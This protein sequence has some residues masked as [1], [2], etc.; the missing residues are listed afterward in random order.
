MA[1]VGSRELLV[2][3][4]LEDGEFKYARYIQ[5]EVK[6]SKLVLFKGLAKYLE[7]PNYEIERVAQDDRVKEKLQESTYTKWL[8]RIV[9]EYE[10]D[11]Q[12]HW[13]A[14]DTYMDFC[15][16]YGD[17]PNST[18]VAA[19]GVIMAN[20]PAVLPSRGQ[21]ITFNGR[22]LEE[23]G[24]IKYDLLSID[25]LC[26]I[27]DFYGLDI[28]WSGPKDDEAV[29]KVFQDGDTDFTFQF[30]SN[31]M[32]RILKE[33]KPT[34]IA[35]L[36]AINALFRPGPIEMGMVDK[37]IELASG[38]LNLE[39]DDLVLSNLLKEQ[40]GEDHA[41]LVIYQ[42]DV[43]KICQ[44]GAGFTLTEAD[45]I[46]KAMGKKDEQKMLKYKPQF[47]NG[48]CLEGDPLVI[49][50]NLEKF[51]HYAF[52]KSHA[53]AYAV[54]A[55][56]TARIWAHEKNRFL[57][58]HLNF[59]DA[60]KAIDKCSQLGYKDI[61]P[62]ITNMANE[63]Y[64]IIDKTVLLPGHATENVDTFVK[65]LF[66]RD[67]LSRNK[68]IYK[69]VCDKLTFDRYGLANLI[70]NL[71]AKHK[72]LAMYMEGNGE[73]FTSLEQILDGLKLIGAVEEWEKNKSEYKIRVVKL[74]SKADLIIR[75]N[76]NSDVVSDRLLYDMKHFGK[77]RTGI[78]S[79]RL[80]KCPRD[81]PTE[82]MIEKLKETQIAR[83]GDN[84]TPIKLY[85]ILKEK[86][87]EILRTE[88]SKDINVYRVVITKFESG[89]YSER[90]ICK[91]SN[92]EEFL[93]APSKAGIGTKIRAMK[94]RKPFVEITVKYSPFI[95]KKTNEYI[96][97][98]DVIDIKEI[99]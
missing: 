42:E 73:P 95:R 19:S 51:S 84:A 48:W 68:L 39:G 76:M 5:N 7:I 65:F 79:D 66:D 30:G 20:E 23:K 27:Q 58:Y 60:K 45:H 33:T 56:E 94:S 14:V 52:N 36:A 41:G 24:F 70:D 97:D 4:L 49:W 57:E 10:L 92:S 43:M 47:I 37:Y 64:K 67:F 71:Q 63:Q 96:S 9:V 21:T 93:T 90:V 13:D 38:T 6:A 16:K 77:P 88:T 40:F 53:V 31:G 46:R 2:D 35:A 74:R 82:R 32:K 91:F 28:D 26:P 69:G 55:Y 17:I 25:A 12:D 34:T 59:G 61:F 72:D 22:D 15:Y 87:D 85:Y 80:E 78:L 75:S 62:D 8:Q 99:E 11:W 54:I 83:L 81:E 18:S 98:Y 89:S 86:L 44:V 1:I 29:W 3:R 50:E